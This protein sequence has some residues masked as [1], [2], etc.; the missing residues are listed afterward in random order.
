MLQENELSK[1]KNISF[2]MNRKVDLRSKTKTTVGLHS[3]KLKSKA[4]TLTCSITSGISRVTRNMIPHISVS[5]AMLL[6]L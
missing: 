4:P 2:S 3:K 6:R 1:A 5:C